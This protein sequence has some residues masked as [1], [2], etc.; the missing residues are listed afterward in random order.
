V[1]L[2]EAPKPGQDLEVK[3]QPYQFPLSVE[4]CFGAFFQFLERERELYQLG[5]SQASGKFCFTLWPGRII[6]VYRKSVFKGGEFLAGNAA[7]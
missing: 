1:S 6:T 5:R 2:S 4:R 3:V 7:L